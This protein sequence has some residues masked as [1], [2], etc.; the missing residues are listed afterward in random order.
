VIPVITTTVDFW[1]TT[2]V[3]IRITDEVRK[4]VDRLLAD[5]KCLGHEEVIPAGDIVRCGQCTKCYTR[6]LR[7]IAAGEVTRAALIRSG[8]MLPPG[9]PG[10]KANDRYEEKLAE[11]KQ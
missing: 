4:R 8:M 10:P 3:A 2:K 11:V 5:G 1:E 7:R 6:S 9:K